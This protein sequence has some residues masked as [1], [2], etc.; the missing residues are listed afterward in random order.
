MSYRK[1]FAVPPGS[2]V[3]LGDVD[4][5]FAAKHKSKREAAASLARYDK[6]LGELQYL[7]YANHSRS[8]LICLQG[9]DASGKDG[10]VRHV[11]S[12]LDPLGARAHAFKTP[13]QEEADHDF[14]WRAHLRAPAKGDVAIFNRSH[15]EDVLIVRVHDLVPK[16]VWSKRYDLINDFERNL[17]LA[18][19][20]IL[21]FFLHISP[22]EQLRRFKK[23]LDD[24]TRQWKI[25]EADYSERARFKQYTAAYEEMLSKTSTP[26]APWFVIPADHKW[27]RN[28]AVS[29]IV[30]ETL[31]SFDMRFPKSSVDIE[32]I[33]KKYHE[34]KTVSS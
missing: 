33:R 7:L 6:R 14:L 17:S 11:F 12:R 23:R 21:K 25:S 31:E 22:K 13:S 27:F 20:S 2:R 24:P 15:Y 34:E 16:S 18:G 29:R 8:L 19:T 28:L 1:L 9:I 32:E 10:T 26:Y 3:S 5:G 4:P 30:V